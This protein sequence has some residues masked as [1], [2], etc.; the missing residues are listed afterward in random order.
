MT[1][2]ELLAQGIFSGDEPDR[3]HMASE[4]WRRDRLE[5]LRRGLAVLA[6]PPKAV[7][8]PVAYAVLDSVDCMSNHD[9]ERAARA[10]LAV[11]SDLP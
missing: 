10:A 1:L 3:W 8:W 9:A 6:A 11:L 7:V 5:D 4:Q 2:L